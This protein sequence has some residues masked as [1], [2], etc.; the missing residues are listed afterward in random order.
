MRA[1]MIDGAGVLAAVCERLR[2][3]DRSGAADELTS[4]YPFEPIDPSP[5]R[6]RKA[7]LVRLFGRDG[8]IDRY[9]GARLVH[10]G[11]L[12][13]LSCLLPEQFPVDRGWSSLRTHRAYW[14]LFPTLDHLVPLARGGSD[15]A[16]NWVTTSMVR[17]AAKGNWTSEELGWELKPPGDLKVWDGLSGWFR[18]YLEAHPEAGRGDAH[19]RA[20]RRAGIVS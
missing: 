7:D 12:R 17:N 1:T 16:S 13:L 10:P 3:G 5:R 9:S 8:F 11:A 6:Y 19:V 14:E 4:R 15:D 18:D 2:A 20:W